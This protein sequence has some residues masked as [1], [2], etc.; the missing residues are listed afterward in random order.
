MVRLWS[1]ETGECVAVLA[2]HT[3]RI[4]NLASDTKYVAGGRPGVGLIVHVFR[5]YWPGMK[6]HVRA[7]AEFGVWEH[8]SKRLT[9]PVLRRCLR[10]SIVA[11]GSADTTIKIWN[12]GGKLDGPA[13][14][15][16]G[17]TG[18]VYGVRV[19]PGQVWIALLS[20]RCRGG[21]PINDCLFD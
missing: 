4:W 13:C 9:P 20:A 1:P 6:F 18:D 8:F 15:L 10:G 21:L 2:G 3:S 14:T 17:H 16:T 12:V 5:V 19:H 11:S 7:C